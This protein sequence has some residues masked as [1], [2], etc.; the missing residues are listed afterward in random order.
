MTVENDWFANRSDDEGS[1]AMQESRVSLLL[2]CP[3]C[4]CGIGTPALLS[5]QTRKLRLRG[6]R[7]ARSSGSVASR[8]RWLLSPL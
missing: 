4:F 5:L 3:Q 6:S 1:P 7:M 8:L 2:S